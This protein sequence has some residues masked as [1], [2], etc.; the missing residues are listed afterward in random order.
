MLIEIV[1]STHWRY[2][3]TGVANKKIIALIH[4]HPIQNCRARYHLESQLSDLLT[5][6]ARGTSSCHPPLCITSNGRIP[7]FPALI[8]INDFTRIPKHIHNGTAPVFRNSSPRLSPTNG[9]GAAIVPLASPPPKAESRR[10]RSCRNGFTPASAMTAS[11]PDHPDPAGY[12]F[13]PPRIKGIIVSI[14]TLLHCR[15][16]PRTI[17]PLIR[18]QVFIVHRLRRVPCQGG[19]QSGMILCSGHA[20]IPTGIRNYSRSRSPV[21]AACTS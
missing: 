16:Y 1:F 14:S 12:G 19:S 9:R 7:A 17:M 15:L 4:P 13:P 11:S 3:A 18:L 10:T 20:H 5:P 21:P 8:A 6:L 2:G